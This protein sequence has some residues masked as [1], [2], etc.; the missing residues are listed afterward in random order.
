ME[1][2]KVEAQK[3]PFVCH[4]I[5]ASNEVR[6]ELTT[7]WV[8]DADEAREKAHDWIRVRIREFPTVTVLSCPGGVSIDL[9]TIYPHTGVISLPGQYTREIAEQMGRVRPE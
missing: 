9:R 8:R 1:E 4:L 6:H 7:V 5:I 3:E 2:A